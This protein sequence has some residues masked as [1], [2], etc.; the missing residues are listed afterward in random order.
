MPLTFVPPFPIYPPETSWMRSPSTTLPALVLNER[1]GGGRVAYLPADVDRCYG[2]D[3]LP[4]HGRLLANLSRWASRDRIPLRVEGVGLLD[5]HLYRQAG[6]LVLHLVN[7]SNPGA[8]R[9]AL[10]ELIPVGPFSVAVQLPDGVGG[11]SA[12]L[13][14][15]DGTAT[16]TVADG[17][18]TLEVPRILDHEVVVIA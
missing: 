2:R 4:D 17:W 16:T 15:A 1:P 10:H 13:L 5:C 8:W 7:L 9:Q 3:N 6:R 14:V 18:A 11:R 12:R